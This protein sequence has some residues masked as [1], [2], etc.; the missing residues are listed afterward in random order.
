M[1]GPQN[2]PQ[3]IE[4]HQGKAVYE[5]CLKWVPLHTMRGFS[6]PQAVTLLHTHG[7]IDE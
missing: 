7:D 2:H 4:P 5:T 3:V 1:H 6:L